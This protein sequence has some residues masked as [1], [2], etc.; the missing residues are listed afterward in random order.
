MSITIDGAL[1][2]LSGELFD[3]KKIRITNEY[4]SVFD[5]IQV[6]GGVTKNSVHNTWKRMKET[7]GE[8]V[9][10]H[11][12]DLKFAGPGQRETVCVN[13]QGLVKLLMWIP[14]EKAK[15]F[16]ELT[17]D[18][19]IRYLGGDLTLINDV[20]NINTSHSDGT[21]MDIF[22]QQVQRK[23]LYDESYFIYIRVYNRY[24]EEQQKGLV[25]DNIKLSFDV[26]KFG[27]AKHIQNRESGYG[28]DNGFF[29]YALKVRNKE[30]AVMIE[31]M[32]RQDF[33]DFTVGN[34]YEYLYSKKLAKHLKIN[35]SDIL[36][37]RDHYKTAEA[38]YTKLL[39]DYHMNFPEDNENFGIMYHP[40]LENEK[41][42]CSEM[43][44]APE[45]LSSYR[46][47]V[48]VIE[49]TIVECTK[50]EIDETLQEELLFERNRVKQLE[51]L[52]KIK[53]PELWNEY[54]ETRDNAEKH[55]KQYK[56][57][58]VNQYSIDGKFIKTFESISAA[59]KFYECSTKIIRI[60]CQNHKSFSGFLW[61]SGLNNTDDININQIEKCDANDYKIL[62]T[63]NT[64]VEI[65]NEFKTDSEF[66]LNEVN[67]AIDLGLVYCGY[68]W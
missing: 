50:E 28:N 19:M 16:R 53:N 62:K 45:H 64:F 43:L 14:G 55:K 34:S 22:R 6:A 44:L 23:I 56:K 39:S 26:I 9:L 66:V 20:K 21:N 17:A 36:E 41:I 67:R 46:L 29:Q 68:R 2:K 11:C 33:K 57:N 48:K 32:S 51:E 15:K 31:K 63:Y 52:I 58:K 59:A 60:S 47:P 12:K 25:C 24:F 37:K 61:R 5:I 18:V 30:S 42:I 3:G 1:M 7:Y 4:V 40:K 10:T 38:L 65:D 35:E 13:V 54:S 49:P 8:E 27:I